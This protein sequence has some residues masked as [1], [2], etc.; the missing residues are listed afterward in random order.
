MSE[1]FERVGFNQGSKQSPDSQNAPENRLSKVRKSSLEIPENRQEPNGTRS[2]RIWT[3]AMHWIVRLLIA[4]CITLGIGNTIG[5]IALRSIGAPVTFSEYLTN[6]TNPKWFL[7]INVVSPAIPIGIFALLTKLYGEP[8]EGKETRCRQCGHILRGLS[9]PQCTECGEPYER[10]AKPWQA[11]HKGDY[12]RINIAMSVAA[13]WELIIM[14]PQLTLWK[15]LLP[16]SI[17]TAWVWYAD[18]SFADGCCRNCGYDLAWQCQWSLPR[19]RSGYMK[20]FFDRRSASM[21]SATTTMPMTTSTTPG[22]TWSSP[23]PFGSTAITPSHDD[24]GNL[25]DDGTYKY[26]YDAWNRLVKATLDDTDITIQEAS[27]R[28]A[29]PQNQENG[30]EFRRLGWDDRVSLQ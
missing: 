24:N 14:A 17:L 19:M 23:S 8:R 27:I 18:R 30:H 6:L 21:N 9:R 20:F 2:N 13:E 4:A 5:Y 12:A 1:V 15:F 7:V 3:K 29:G 16:M 22:T 11:N 26:T 10:I 28:R 25:T